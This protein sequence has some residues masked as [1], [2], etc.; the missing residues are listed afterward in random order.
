MSTPAAAAFDLPWAA[1]LHCFNFLPSRLLHPSWQPRFDLGGALAVLA[2]SCPAPILHRHWSAHILQR[3]GLAQQ[4][5]LDP[6]APGL[7]AAILPAPEFEHLLQLGGAVLAGP[8][9]RHAIRRDDCR[10]LEQAL[11]PA[12]LGFARQQA[13]RLHPGVE[14]VLEGGLADLAEGLSEL[15]AGLL[16][17]ALHAA[18]DALFE[19]LRLRLPVTLTDGATPAPLALAARQLEPAVALRLILRLVKEID[20]AW[21]HS[22]PT[23]H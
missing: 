20:P 19:R 7:L 5:V 8:L 9:V 16:L 3:L 17:Q 18:D 14:L 1:A 10:V 21:S 11:G 15:G 4:P 23:L 13:R 12:L 2:E 6:S 22:S